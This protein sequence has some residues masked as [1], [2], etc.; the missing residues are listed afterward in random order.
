ML[1]EPGPTARP[2]FF[3]V[4]FRAPPSGSAPPA[5]EVGVLVLRDVIRFDGSPAPAG[6][7]RM[8]DE[9]FQ[10]NEPSGPFRYEAEIAT[11]KTWLDAVIVHDR[12]SSL[13]P[14]A[15]GSVRVDRGAGFGG[16]HPRNFGWASRSGGARLA[17]AGNAGAFNPAQDQ[18]PQGYTNDFSNGAALTNELPLRA[19]NRLRFDDTTGPLVSTTLLIPPGPSLS[20]TLDGR[21]LQPPL[22][23]VPGVDTV[24]MDRA[25]ATF[26]LVWRASFAWQASLATATLHVN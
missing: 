26:T 12:A 11:A 20:A 9:P 24:V 15:F 6:P 23:L 7:V 3:L 13:V 18:L 17:A 1:V 21:L 25:A 19:G 14:T 22:A 5:Q 16:A 2:H 10:A 4:G 8:E